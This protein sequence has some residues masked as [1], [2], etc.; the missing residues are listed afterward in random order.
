M[1]I[2]IIM[3]HNTNKTIIYRMMFV[4]GNIFVHAYTE[5]GYKIL[6]FELPNL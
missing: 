3:L 6:S 4:V 1:L 5:H 2:K